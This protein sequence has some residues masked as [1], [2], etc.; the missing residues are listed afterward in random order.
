MKKKTIL[1]NNNIGSHG[2]IDDGV[3]EYIQRSSETII[4]DKIAKSLLPSIVIYEYKGDEYHYKLRYKA[5]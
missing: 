5:N 3:D 1:N 4:I 2:C